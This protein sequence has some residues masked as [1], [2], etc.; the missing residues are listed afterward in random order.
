[1]ILSYCD[2]RISL[3]FI[4]P[5]YVVTQALTIKARCDHYA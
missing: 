2:F 4:T 5:I 3:L 1:M